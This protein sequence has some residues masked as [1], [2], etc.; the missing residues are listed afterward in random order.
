MDA[1]KKDHMIS[2]RLAA[3]FQR[4]TAPENLRQVPQ[5][6]ADEFADIVRQVAERAPAD[7]GTD[8]E[9]WLGELTEH[10]V[11][12]RRTRQWPTVP[13]MIDAASNVNEQRH[14]EGRQMAVLNTAVAAMTPRDM[15]AAVTA[16]HIQA[17]RSIPE[18]HIYGQVADDMIRL[19]LITKADLKRYRQY[20]YQIRKRTYGEDH[21]DRWVA[22]QQ[23][24]TADVEL[25]RTETAADRADFE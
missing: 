24:V 16:K 19:G 21:A 12:S 13:E 22:Q 15:T 2:D 5:A 4:Y 18:P 14:K 3:L 11:I 17:G 6:Q 8:L 20:A 9:L 25:A 23:G 1:R 7:D 10:L